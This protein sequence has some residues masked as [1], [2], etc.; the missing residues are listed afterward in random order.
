MQS[1]INVNKIAII[2]KERN[3]VIVSKVQNYYNVLAYSHTHIKEILYFVY[4]KSTILVEIL[5]NISI[6]VLIDTCMFNICLIQV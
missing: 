5:I 4:R 6:K 1:F 3:Q 2:F